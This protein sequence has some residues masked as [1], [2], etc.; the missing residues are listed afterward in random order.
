MTPGDVELGALAPEKRVS[1]NPTRHPPCPE[2]NRVWPVPR[3]LVYRL[4][5]LV[6]RHIPPSTSEALVAYQNSD[7]LTKEPVISEKVIQSIQYTSLWRGTTHRLVTEFEY[8]KST[9]EIFYDISA[10]ESSKNAYARLVTLNSWYMALFNT[11]MYVSLSVVDLQGN[12]M[13]LG[14]LFGDM[15][16]A[17]LFH[18]SRWIFMGFWSAI[19]LVSFG[20]AIMEAN[21]EWSVKASA[22]VGD[23]IE[24]CRLEAWGAFLALV[25]FR[26][27]AVE[28]QVK[29]IVIW[30][31]PWKSVQPYAA[32]K[33]EG[34]RSYIIGF[35]NENLFRTEN[36]SGLIKRMPLQILLKT[37]VLTLKV[38]M[39]IF[40]FSL[41]VLL[42]I[43][44]GVPSNAWQMYIWWQ[45]RQDRK[46]C[47]AWL[48]HRLN[49][50]DTTPREWQAVRKL[51][52][53][54]F[55]IKVDETTDRA[56][57]MSLGSP[58]NPSE[59]KCASCGRLQERECCD[60]VES[61][62]PVDPKAQANTGEGS[63]ALAM[64]AA[65]EAGDTTGLTARPGGAAQQAGSGESSGSSMG[66]DRA[67]LR[68]TQQHL[69]VTGLCYWGNAPQKILQV[70]PTGL[71]SS[72]PEGLL[73]AI[74]DDRER[75]EQPGT[76]AS[77]RVAWESEDEVSTRRSLPPLGSHVVTHRQML[78]LDCNGTV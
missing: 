29:D 39:I 23:L 33:I 45:H 74:G 17:K 31:H 57:S 18:T 16:T 51:L 65:R 62:T 61:S 67:C 34:S 50:D 8:G 20:M 6:P 53:L 26:F 19:L 68:H 43:C 77:P 46:R 35:P 32:M 42:S 69:M 7:P 15:E 13:L 14:S 63:G 54:H 73:P 44:S 37:I 55:G 38:Y 24:T 10:Q 76:V 52:A 49:A 9:G 21:K 2:S 11:I 22:H 59:D 58:T 60:S 56:R 25:A 5:G 30:L 4:V 36:H 66:L 48:L 40:N 28:A 3:Q 1:T 70:V 27:F 78:P 41:T 71:S 64:P 75:C 12:V 47:K 72:T